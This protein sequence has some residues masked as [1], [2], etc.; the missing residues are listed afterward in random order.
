MSR[1]NTNQL[2]ILSKKGDNM[3]RLI[4]LIR[5]YKVRDI[6]QLQMIVFWVTLIVSSAMIFY[7]IW[8][9]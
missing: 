4:Q 9:L 3:T 7:L 6:A 1:Q 5:T 8:K 2:N